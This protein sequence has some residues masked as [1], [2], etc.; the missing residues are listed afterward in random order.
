MEDDLA[1]L[2][3]RITGIPVMT[4][5]L[6]LVLDTPEGRIDYGLVGMRVVTTAGVNAIV[7]AIEGTFTISNWK[8]HGFG[9]GTGAEAIGDTALGTE[10]TTEYAV[11]STRPTGT[12]VD[13]ASANIYESVATFAPDSGGTLAVTEHGIFSATSA[14]T[15]LDR[16]K[17]A[18]INLVAASDSLQATYDLT[19]ASG[20]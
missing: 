4:G 9:I 20:G 18:A 16:T 11:N 19:F 6:Y 17:F 3:S 5:R 12:Q 13:G 10:F 15:L 1:E 2:V 7:D 8:Y 14:G